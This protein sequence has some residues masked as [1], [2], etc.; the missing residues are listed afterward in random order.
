VHEFARGHNQGKSGS[1]AMDVSLYAD[2]QQTQLTLGQHTQTVGD[3]A[4]AIAGAIPGRITEAITEIEAAHREDQPQAASSYL[5]QLKGLYT[6]DQSA[7]ITSYLR[8]LRSVNIGQHMPA[9]SM[10][11]E[12]LYS[13]IVEAVLKGNEMLVHLYIKGAGWGDYMKEHHPARTQLTL[14]A[15]NIGDAGAEALATNNTLMTLDVGWNQIGAK[16]AAALTKNTHLTTLDVSDNYIGADGAV[17]L[18]AG[19]QHNKNLLVYT[20]ARENQLTAHLA[21]NRQR[22]D[23]YVARLVAGDMGSVDRQDV[24]ARAN[25]ITQCLNERADISDERKKELAEQVKAIAF[26]QASPSTDAGIGRTVPR[27]SRRRE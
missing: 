27:G 21:D 3:I 4:R 23:A 20:G 2:G 22:A 6:Q 8:S 19:L 5:R 12:A 10:V 7:R 13:P 17:A 24:A 16:G 14:F 18:V 1:F 26:D 25:A 11:R 15:K 9:P